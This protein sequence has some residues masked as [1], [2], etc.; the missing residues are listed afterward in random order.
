MPRARPPRELWADIRRRI[1]ARDGWACVRCETSL[2]EHTAHVDHVHSG[3]LGTN[4]LANLRTLCRRCHVLRADPRH[5]GMVAT[6]LRD[7]IIPPNWRA[8]VWSDEELIPRTTAT[9]ADG[10]VQD[11]GAAGT[12]PSL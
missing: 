2:T 8:L 12:Q 6:A 9:A 11:T 7:G 10:E 5:R 1:L 4:A 3:Q